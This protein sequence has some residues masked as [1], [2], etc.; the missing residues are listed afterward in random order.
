MLYWS[1]GIILG[2]LR[3]LWDIGKLAMFGHFWPQKGHYIKGF[4]KGGVGGGA[5]VW[6]KFPNNIVFFGWARTWALVVGISRLI[7]LK[8]VKEGY[9][10]QLSWENA[11]LDIGPSEVCALLRKCKHTLENSI[12]SVFWKSVKVIMSWKKSLKKSTKVIMPWNMFA[13]EIFWW[14]TWTAH[15]SSHR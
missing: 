3:P 12:S 1:S 15:V 5:D 7:L 10:V 4:P 2:P 14:S 13:G 6:E 11:R 8:C 9:K